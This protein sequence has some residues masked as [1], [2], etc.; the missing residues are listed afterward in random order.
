MS[1]NIKIG[2]G[3]VKHLKDILSKYSPSKLMLITGKESYVRSG[4]KDK[5][6]MYLS[7]YNYV[8]FYNFDKNPKYK[9]VLKGLSIFK[10]NKCDLILTVGGGSVIDMGKNINAFQSN[11]NNN[12]V[13]FVSKN[14]IKNR[15]V[16]LVA[17]PTTSGTGS[18]STHF[19]VIYMDKIKYSLSSDYL[20]PKDAIIDSDFCFFQTKYQIASSGMDAFC[21]AIESYWA[22]NSTDLS[23]E[24]A[25]KAIILCNENIRS[26]YKHKDKEAIHNMAVAANYSGKAINISKTTAPHSVSYPITSYIGLPHGHAVSLTLVEFLKFNYNITEDTNNDIRG[27]RYVKENIDNIFILLGQECLVGT[28]D[29]LNKLLYDLNL[30][31]DSIRDKINSSI[32]MIVEF[33]FNVDR[34]NNN[35]RKLSIND[36]SKIL[37]SI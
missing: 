28:V 21:Q 36:L 35:P 13:E 34:I 30:L 25:A 27:I 24:Y 1:Q 20:I 3:S 5:I 29:Y 10:K 4:A 7:N 23:K 11:D 26:A 33:G 12:Y 8:H 6:E 37:K 2:L 17:I 32:D 16:P 15:G 31:S 14:L 18:E 22:V 9:D 19:S